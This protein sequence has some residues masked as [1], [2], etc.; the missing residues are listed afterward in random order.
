MQCGKR[1]FYGFVALITLV[2][3]FFVA[4]VSF[5]IGE[6]IVENIRIQNVAVGK[7]TRTQALQEL[8]QQ[9]RK[10]VLKLSYKNK[11]YYIT[12]EDIGY[13]YDY[14][15]SI[16]QVYQVGRVPQENIYQRYVDIYYTRQYGR[17]YQLVCT[18]DK[19]LLHTKIQEIIREI[20]IQPQDA[21]LIG[22]TQQNNLQVEQIGVLV[23]AYG[24]Y[25]QILEALHKGQDC[26]IR[27][28]TLN[29]LPGRYAQDL[30]KFKKMLGRQSFSSDEADLALVDCLDGIVWKKNTSISWQQQ[31]NRIEKSTNYSSPKGNSQLML[32][33]F[34]QLSQ[35]LQLF[36]ERISL[37]E[38][39]K[40]IVQKGNLDLIIR[41]NSNQDI[42]I[43]CYKERNKIYLEFWGEN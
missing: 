6:Q 42:Y 31:L 3:F 4:S 17:S 38:A 8:K 26:E 16:E 5:D 9:I 2:T 21:K 23:E 24:L 43:S 13:E 18:Y 22:S 32:E 15:A 33:G 36:S 14:Q 35:Q 20:Q 25:Y 10:P 29:F 28:E 37:D 7:L 34:Y 30:V 1:K 19:E 11:N 39:G 40:L 12:P 41:N 27:I